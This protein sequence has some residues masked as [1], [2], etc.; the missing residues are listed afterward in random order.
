ML[1]RIDVFVYVC[2]ER[3]QCLSNKSGQLILKLRNTQG[4]AM[5]VIGFGQMQ[6]ERIMEN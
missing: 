5:H 6:N 4:G 3:N 2:F 1:C